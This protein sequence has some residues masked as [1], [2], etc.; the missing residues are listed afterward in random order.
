MGVDQ[1]PINHRK[2]IIDDHLYPLSEP[3]ETEME[4]TR[5]VVRGFCLPFLL[6]I[7]RHQLQAITE[8]LIKLLSIKRTK[9]KVVLKLLYLT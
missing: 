4:Y 6:S 7:M 5:V 2:E 9:Q 8:F 3:P 1:S